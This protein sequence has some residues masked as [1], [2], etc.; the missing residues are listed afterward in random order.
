MKA[1]PN[2]RLEPGEP[3]SA[4]FLGQ[5]VRVTRAYEELASI[6]RRRIM[7]GELS[8]GER[9]PSESTLAQ[10]AQVSR[11]T[12]REALRTLEE[13]GLIARAS[14]K[15][16]VV[17]AADD[18]RAVRDLEGAL[19]SRNVSFKHLHEALLMLEPELTR[20]AALRGEAADIAELETNLAEQAA[21][22]DNFPTW[23]VLDQQFHVT[24][25]RMS[26]NPALVL[27]GAP[28][29]DLLAPLLSEF[30]IS[31]SL[32][33]RA[34]DFHRRILEEIQVRDA[35]AA[36]LM[37]RKHVND[38]RAI[39]EQAGLELELEIEAARDGVQMAVAGW[40]HL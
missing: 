30:M 1:P 21:S 38:L 2:P 17:T 14:P 31:T 9:I 37:A 25:A 24:I 4:G 29:S 19:R 13:A 8:V 26:G 23:S 15:I 10:E 39:W 11:S 27:I 28:I 12:V 20:L 5:P 36:A 22:L 34:L 35:D 33:Q 18:N 16:M 6:I 40:Q 3:Q 7:A 32:T